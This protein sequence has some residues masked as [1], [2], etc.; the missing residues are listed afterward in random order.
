MKIDPFA[1]HQAAAIVR[2]LPPA[3]PRREL[4][5]KQLAELRRTIPAFR[6]LE[7]RSLRSRGVNVWWD[8]QP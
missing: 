4:S 6:E 5:P 8:R 2:D 3:P 7:A 1:G